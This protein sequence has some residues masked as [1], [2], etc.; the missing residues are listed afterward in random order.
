MA[1]YELT[2][3]FKADELLK[4]FFNGL[5]NEEMLKAINIDEENNLKVKVQNKKNKIKSIEPITSSAIY[6]V[7]YIKTIS[8]QEEIKDKVLLV[9]EDAKGEIKSNVTHDISIDFF[10]REL[11][12]E[13]EIPLSLSILI[14]G[15]PI[16]LWS[17]SR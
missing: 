10:V 13:G 3:L 5:S 14:Q 7:N 8:E 6:K 15:H 4:V 9:W 1:S 16:V 17:A 11:F 12:T 2:E